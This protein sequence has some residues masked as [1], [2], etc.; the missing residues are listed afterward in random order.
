MQ[1]I[2]TSLTGKIVKIDTLYVAYWQL[3]APLANLDE[4]TLCILNLQK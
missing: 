1:F 2:F 4:E 3:I